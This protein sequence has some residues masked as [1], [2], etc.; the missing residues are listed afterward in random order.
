VTGL[1]LFLC[2]INLATLFAFRADKAAAIAG[3]WRIAESNLLA[4]ALFGGTPAAFA[5]RHLYRHKTRKQP[6]ST[7]LVLIAAIQAGAVAGWMLS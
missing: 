5:A 1:L 3:E 7:Y 6:F 4:L 2:A